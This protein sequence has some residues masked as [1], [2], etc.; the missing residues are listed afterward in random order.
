MD[1]LCTALLMERGTYIISY[2]IFFLINGMYYFTH[3]P[4]SVIIQNVHF[5]DLD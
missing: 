4:P 5:Y 2:S 1:E 3:Q